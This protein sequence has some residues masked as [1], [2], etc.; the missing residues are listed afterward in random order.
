MIISF[1][2]KAPFIIMLMLILITA[3]SIVYISSIMDNIDTNSTDC[4]SCKVDL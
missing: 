4:C 1:N 3:V 2:K